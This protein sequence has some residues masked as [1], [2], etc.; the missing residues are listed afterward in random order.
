[1]ANNRIVW[2]GLEDLKAALR[3]LPA[4]L[5]ADASSI[6][7]GAA[8]EAA[9]AIRSA[10]PARTGNLKDHV[11]VTGVS[12]GT[13]GA[14]AVVKN[15]AKHAW[16]F[17]NGTQA[18]HT[19]LGANRGSMPPGHVFIPTVIRKRREMYERLKAVLVSHGLVAAGDP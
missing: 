3:A 5:A 19:S 9:D 2:D 4:E 10:Y 7:T 1:M 12:A 14:G 8:Q 17:E 11:L 15:T 13:Y 18:R 6:V 16:I